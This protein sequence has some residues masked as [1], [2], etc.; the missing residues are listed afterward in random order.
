ML[1]ES[2]VIPQNQKSSLAFPLVV[3]VR[4]RQRSPEMSTKTIIEKRKKLI[5]PSKNL[6]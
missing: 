3:N 4:I 5:L 2:Y 6:N 1:I